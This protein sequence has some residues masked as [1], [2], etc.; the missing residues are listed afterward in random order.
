MKEGELVPIHQSMHP[1]QCTRS[2]Q[3]RSP[4]EGSPWGGTFAGSD[5]RTRA[6]VHAAASQG[7]ATALGTLCPASCPLPTWAA[8]NLQESPRLP[9]PECSI[10][11]GMSC[12]ALRLA[13]SFSNTPPRLLGDAVARGLTPCRAD[14][15]DL[16]G[17]LSRAPR[18][19]IFLLP[20]FGGCERGRHRHLCAGFC[21]DTKLQA[22]G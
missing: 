9:F 22:L 2:G 1:N 21:A 7:R 3:V 4:G 8:T 19:S 14:V 18:K 16:P 6:C 12:G 13:S 11:A 10:V 20:G 5:K 17:A 15:P